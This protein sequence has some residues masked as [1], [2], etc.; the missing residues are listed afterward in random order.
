MAPDS[1][2][3]C[4]SEKETPRSEDLAGHSLRC[5]FLMTCR[6]AAALVNATLLIDQKCS[7]DGAAEGPERR[8]DCADDHTVK[9]QTR[10]L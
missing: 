8:G 3:S 2:T 9:P 6:E 10:S 5:D 4:E 7:R 1:E